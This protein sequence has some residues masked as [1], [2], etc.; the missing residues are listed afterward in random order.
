M[1]ELA[2]LGGPRIVPRNRRIPRWPDLAPEDEEAVRRVVASGRYTAAAAGE[3]EIAGLERDWA[4]EVGTRHCVAVSNGTT[5]L[6]LALAAAGVGPGDEVIVPALSFIATAITPL[7]LSAVPVFADVDPVTFNVAPKAVEAA[8]T[9]RTRAIV[10]VHL[11]GL[12]ADLDELA[13]TAGRHGLALVEDAAQAHGARYRGRAV[14]SYGDIGTFSLNVSKN[15]PTCG[16]GGLVTTDDDDLHRRVGMMRQF[17]EMLGG[18]GPR[19]YVSH[20]LGW[21]D[22]P[23]AVQCAFTRSRLGRFREENRIRDENVRHFLGRLGELPWLRGPEAPDDRTHAWHILRFMTD[24]EPF[25][26]G[27]AHTGPV[28]AAVMKALRAEGVPATHYQLM[29]LPG[30]R[31]FRR[32]PIATEDHYRASDWPNTLEVIDGSFTIQKAHLSPKARP[33]LDLYADA[34]TK[35]WENRDAIAREAREMDYRPPWQEAEEIAE[36]ELPT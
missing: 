4:E 14:G 2:M 36:Q 35:V 34:A 20:V 11:H 29:P 24:P 21:N 30:Q 19:S 25:G 33:M 32:P 22:K 7:H 15:L 9:P 8:V 12:P 3:K 17:G 31:V 28:R 16:E 26:L 18:G 1:S 13:A 23:N 5:A 10:V 27:P 6:S